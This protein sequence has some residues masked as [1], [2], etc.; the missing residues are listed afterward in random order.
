[1]SDIKLI[2]SLYPNPTKGA[3][4]YTIGDGQYCVGGAMV[5]FNKRRNGCTAGV[6]DY[7]PTIGKLELHLRALNSALP[8]LIAREYATEIILA[9]ERGQMTT[10]WMLARAALRYP[11][12]DH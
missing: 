8:R 6:E 7:F 9:N 10:A 1:M 3:C 11:T 12:T 5:L 2:Q 4:N